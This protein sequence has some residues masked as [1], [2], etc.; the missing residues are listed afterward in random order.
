MYHNEPANARRRA[1]WPLVVLG[2]FLILAAVTMAGL[3]ARAG[4]RHPA[5]QGEAT[6]P[7]VTAPA[8]WADIRYVQFESWTVP[9]STDHGP[10]QTAAGLASGYTHDPEGAVLAAANLVPRA[11]SS[12]EQIARATVSTQAVSGAITKAAFLAAIGTPPTG[13]PDMNADQQKAVIGYL[14][15]AGSGPDDVTVTLLMRA[16]GIDLQTDA[17]ALGTQATRVRW[18]AGDWRLVLQSNPGGA[19]AAAP[20]GMTA[21]PGQTLTVDP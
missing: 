21:L 12:N 19:V 15:S 2:V 3:A 14:V 5:A 18:V 8:S 10:R 4:R 16:T 17:H 6:A 7:T 9:T 20:S 11:L 1:R 13:P